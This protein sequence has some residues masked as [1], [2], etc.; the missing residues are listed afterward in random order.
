MSYD[1]DDYKT[2]FVPRAG[3][4]YLNVKHLGQRV[5]GHII[6]VRIVL[7]N[8]QQLCVNA[9]GDVHFDTSRNLDDST[10]EKLP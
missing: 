1:F 10:W 3:Q 6:M 7:P 4:A 9:D 8:R 5:N 2:T